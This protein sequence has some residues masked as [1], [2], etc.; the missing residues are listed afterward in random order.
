MSF[1]FLLV[2]IY[3]LSA[4][5]FEASL[6]LPSTQRF[7]LIQK[8]KIILFAV[9]RSAYCDKKIHFNGY[10][11]VIK[12]SDIHP[13]FFFLQYPCTL[14]G[15]FVKGKLRWFLGHFRSHR[16]SVDKEFKKSLTLL[17]FKYR[18]FLSSQA[19]FVSDVSLSRTQ[20]PKAAKLPH[21]VMNI[22]HVATILKK[23]YTF[24]LNVDL[25][26]L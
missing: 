15:N 21:T 25:P 18:N 1:L 2:Y 20:N 23:R 22:L 19:F 4:E 7:Q 14:Y 8:L 17:F 13:F 3:V 11:R 5:H 10:N 9:N 12:A 6:V 24:L 26:K 16:A